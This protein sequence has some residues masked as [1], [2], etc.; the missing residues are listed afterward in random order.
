MDIETLKR[1]ITLKSVID[2]ADKNIEK[3]ENVKASE[4]I[5]II[6]NGF[7]VQDALKGIYFDS[8]NPAPTYYTGKLKEKIMDA[9][10]EEKIKFRD[11]RLEEF[12]K[13]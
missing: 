9:V 11:E 7:Q 1:A 8:K 10:L 6:V 4:E 2:G 12:K 13:L 3:L 5:M